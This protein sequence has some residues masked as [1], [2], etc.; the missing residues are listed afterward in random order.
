MPKLNTANEETAEYLLEIAQYWIK[1]FDIDAWRLDVANEIDHHFW[2]RFYAAT[3]ELKSD[4]YILGEVWH[5]AQEWVE[6]EEFDAA[7]NY[8]F[9]ESIALDFVKH[10]TTASEM[11]SMLSEHLMK[12]RDQTNEVMLNAMDTHDTARLLTLCHGNKSFSVRRLRSCSRSP[13]L[14]AFTMARK[15]GSTAALIRDVASA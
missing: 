13:V 4:F 15:S 12:Y 14:L 11:V 5:S 1:E 8:P 6:Q 3:H 2:K 7:M 9:T 10:E